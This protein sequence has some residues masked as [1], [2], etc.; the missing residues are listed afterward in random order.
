MTAGVTNT[1]PIYPDLTVPPGADTG[2]Y[3]SGDDDAQQ[4][5]DSGLNQSQFPGLDDTASNGL[6]S[7]DEYEKRQQIFNPKDH[8]TTIKVVKGQSV[9]YT[10]EYPIDLKIVELEAHKPSVKIQSISGPVE[11]YIIN[12]S[13]NTEKRLV[14]IENV[15]SKAMHYLFRLS[16]RL[17]VNCVYYGG[18]DMFGKYNCIRCL[19]DDRINDGQSMTLD[20]CLNCS[21]YEPMIGQ[22][23]DILDSSGQNLAAIL[24]DNQMAYMTMQEYITQNRLEEMYSK[25]QTAD[26]KKDAETTPKSFKEIWGA[27]EG[28]SQFTMDWTETPVESQM[29]HIKSYQYGDGPLY[30][31]DGILQQG[32]ANAA[33]SGGGGGGG[34]YS[35][36]VD[37]SNAMSPEY[38]GA[39]SSSDSFIQQMIDGAKNFASGSAPATI[40]NMIQYGYKDDLINASL[41]AG[42]DPWL[43]L[44]IVATESNGNP[45]DSTGTYQGLMQVAG[46]G[47]DPKLNIIAGLNTY[48]GKKRS[49][50]TSK[51]VFIVTA[52]NSGEGVLLGTKSAPACPANFKEIRNTDYKWCDFVLQL[53]TQV[54]KYFP[55]YSVTEKCQ[56]FPRVMYCFQYLKQ[57]CQNRAYNFY[58]PPNTNSGGGKYDGTFMLPL[59]ASDLAHMYLTSDYGYR[60]NPTKPGTRQFHN[61]LDFA[62][63]KSL[64]GNSYFIYAAGNGKV[65]VAGPAGTAGNMVRIQHDNGYYTEYMHMI[66]NSIVVKVGDNVIAGA[67]IGEMG[68]TGSSTAKHLHFGVKTISGSAPVDPKQFLSSL[69][70]KEGRCLG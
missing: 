45:N 52:Y 31:A 26:L 5:D 54:E 10:D 21:R 44:A 27:D 14:Q 3:N 39:V 38:H 16:S 32:L 1:E 11:P 15:L 41:A 63:L 61:G 58:T 18:Q 36:V 35:D 51:E 23:Y 12:L 65:T 57:E 68:T 37:S 64:E 66:N 47:T 13:V 7:K 50:Q 22:I 28:Y 8:D 19:H 43:T 53:K 40:D 49:L 25:K 6:V 24:D 67:K 60:N 17:N 33:A 59:A 9:N 29:P 2:E 62:P 4:Q 46:G 30:D 55:N 70:G 69:S 34:A 42:V 56:Y 48:N 20:Q